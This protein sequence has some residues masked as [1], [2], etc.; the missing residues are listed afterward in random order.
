MISSSGTNDWEPCRQPHAPPRALNSQHTTRLQQHE[1]FL[2]FLKQ[3]ASPPHQ[4]VTAGGRI[5]PTGPLSP[6][7]MFDYA[8]LNGLIEGQPT[9]NQILTGARA[10]APYNHEFG[11]LP[12]SS[13]PEFRPTY[14][15]IQSNQP[16]GPQT[17][18]SSVI[19][20]SLNYGSTPYAQQPIIHPMAESPPSPFTLTPVGVFPDGTALISCN[21][22]SYRCYWNGITTIMDPITTGQP[23]PSANETT[24]NYLPTEIGGSSYGSGL[25]ANIAPALIAQ[26]PTLPCMGNPAVPSGQRSQPMDSTCKSTSSSEEIALKG[27]LT[28]LDKHLALHH[29]D[30]GPAEKTQLISSRKTLVEAI[31]KLRSDREPLKQI[32]PIVAMSR[33]GNRKSSAHGEVAKPIGYG[34]H[35]PNGNTIRDK[36]SHEN[37]ISKKCLSPS[38]PA[39]VPMHLKGCF[40]SSR[41]LSLSP[42][43][44]TA[45]Q[46]TKPSTAIG[47]PSDDSLNEVTNGKHCLQKKSSGNESEPYV[48]VDPWD[49]AMKIIPQSMIQY[50]QKYNGNSP[51]LGKKFCTTIEEFQE[52]I[53]RV[54]EQARMWGC[55]GGNSKD[56][57]YDAEEDIWYAIKDEY[58]IPLPTEIPDHITCPRPWNWYDSAF[59]VKATIEPRINMRGD[60]FEDICLRPKAEATSAKYTFADILPPTKREL[61]AAKSTTE[62]PALKRAVPVL[63]DSPQDGKPFG[64]QIPNTLLDQHQSHQP[65]QDPISGPLGTRKQL[66]YH[67]ESIRASNSQKGARNWHEQP[68]SYGEAETTLHLLTHRDTPRGQDQARQAF[69][70]DRISPSQIALSAAQAAYRI[71]ATTSNCSSLAR[72]VPYP[73]TP[74]TT[75]NRSQSNDL[76]IQL[77]RDV[78]KPGDQ[79]KSDE[80]RLIPEDTSNRNAFL[81]SVSPLT[82][83]HQRNATNKDLESDNV[84]SG[85]MTQF[86]LDRYGQTHRDDCQCSS[87]VRVESVDRGRSLSKLEDSRTWDDL[88]GFLF[89]ESKGAWGP[90]Q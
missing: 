4:R 68:P 31:A 25:Y 3:H 71:K 1:G 13:K 14:T 90:E 44:T 16:L 83:K 30:I 43:E 22:I 63:G 21:G 70:S 5:V 49:P 51:G 20:E 73:T 32:I 37:K 41:T 57:A 76:K 78:A 48:E 54:R 74:L 64:V 15:A 75:P 7:P 56:P 55:V 60:T 81:S 19:Q 38:A 28:S 77:G 45:V 80:R 6:P 72:V 17:T 53:R 62:L 58:P 87:C 18:N 61:E 34:I 11:S 26:P 39:F 86:A 27:H 10:K 8:S 42:N 35:Q 36:S 69:L 46:V 85:Q 79:S 33:D 24:I 47:K 65:R 29:Y 52:A 2:R 23:P 84:N 88:E 82:R 50:A 40:P 89:P 9:K 12:A 59:N 67:A 66:S